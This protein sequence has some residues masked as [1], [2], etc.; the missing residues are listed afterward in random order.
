MTA[1]VIVT[2]GSGWLGH[3]LVKAL[4]ADGRPL[5]VFQGDVRD[6]VAV[7]QLFDGMQGASV[8]H[9]AGVIHPLRATREFFDVNV[10][11][12]S[13]VLDHARRAG[14]GRLTYVSSNSPFGYRR[15][16]AETFDEA[17]PYNPHLGYGV[18]K[19]EAEQLVLRAGAHGAL[20]TVVVR[21]P[22]FYG[23][24][25]PERQT[26]F[27]R[28]IRRGLFPLFGPGT[29][30]RSL[31]YTDN[32]VDGLLRADAAGASG[33]SYW[34]ADARPVTM[35]EVHD[36]VRRAL[37]AEG[38]ETT[39]R[40]L[41]LPGFLCEVAGWADTLAQKAGRYVQ[42]VHVLSEMNKTIACTIDRARDELGYEPRVDLDEGMRRSV[43]W[44]IDQG[45]EL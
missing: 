6:P 19:M 7:A 33:R 37:A 11:G 36:S 18:S 38:L 45:I 9:C 5:R 1:P 34:I 31:V 8:F 12:T 28:A 23:P 21:A 27:F 16:P 40:Q 2:G 4:E 20:H 29:N 26:R 3:A 32:L 17:A 14:V 10:G 30:R 24:G 35:A 44:C 43:R 13:L 39:S 41:R 25:Q 15:S 22:W 42:P